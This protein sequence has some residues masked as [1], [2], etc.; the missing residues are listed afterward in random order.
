MKKIGLV[1]FCKANN[2]G[3]VLQ[4]YALQTYLNKL[5][6]KTEFLDIHFNKVDSTN[7]KN[8]NNVKMSIKEKVIN[9][10]KSKYSEIKFE[11]Y[12]KKYLKIND[13]II[14][15]DD[16]ENV[17]PTYDY[18]IVGSDQVWNTDITHKTKAYFLDFTNANKISFAASYGKNDLNNIEKIWSKEELV[19]FKAVSVREYS[20]YKFLQNENIDSKWVCD[21]VFL[22][23]RN[24]W[25]K[26]LKLKLRT[27]IKKKYILVYYMEPS[28]KLLEVIK[29]FSEKLK[30]D[31]KCVCGGINKLNCKYKH[32]NKGGPIE[33]L[34]NVE[35]AELVITNSFHALA[36]SIIFEKKAIVIG[37]S[38]WNA[39]LDS[40]LKV[41][42]NDNKCISE[43]YNDNY[44]EMIINGKEAYE[45]MCIHIEESKKFLKDAIDK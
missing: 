15:G 26:N 21:P 30:I 16:K 10:L 9:K 4:A 45:K 42:N 18:Y 31:V 13:N 20:A 11:I 2:Y 8:S 12:R 1:T 27:T 14:Y 17:Y 39:R 33:F 25:E 38:K 24:E 44:D 41:T 7:S 35:N 40:L 34:N 28:L 6:C 29:Y 43:D 22:I 32:I 36:F 5:D 37:H 19:K 23:D 3:A